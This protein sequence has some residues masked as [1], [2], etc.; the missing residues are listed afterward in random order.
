MGRLSVPLVVMGV[1]VT[2]MVPTPALGDKPARGCPGPFQEITLQGFIE[3]APPGAPVEE[4]EAFFNS[5]NKNEDA[6]ICIKPHPS[7]A[8]LIDNTANQ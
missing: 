5:I 8:N 4:L 6:L 3:G 2:L 7:G 1:S